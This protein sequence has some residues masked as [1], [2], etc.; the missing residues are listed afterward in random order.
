VVDRVDG[1]G[2][3]EPGTSREQK[4]ELPLSYTKASDCYLLRS[5][6]DD[7]TSSTCCKSRSNLTLDATLIRL[8]HLGGQPRPE[9]PLSMSCILCLRLACIRPRSV[10]SPQSCLCVRP[11]R[12]SPATPILARAFPLTA[13]TNLAGNPN[14]DA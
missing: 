10:K 1:K 14:L 7:S 2:E 4:V 5:P 11:V 9:P 8:F 6:L 12:R 13:S 3:N